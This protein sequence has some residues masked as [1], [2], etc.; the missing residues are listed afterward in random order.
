MNKS[1]FN[2]KTPS[3]K[4]EAGGVAFSLSNKEALTQLVV[5]GTFQNTFYAGGEDQLNKML[6]IAEKVDPVFVA[7]LAVYGR[8]HGF[9]KD[10][11][12]VLTALLSKV[13]V[14]LFKKVFP[15]V[16]D[17]GN[18]LRKFISA[19]RSGVVGRKSLGSAAKKQVQKLL[20]T[21]G[22]EWLFRNSIGN[23]PSMADI[24]KMVHPKGTTKE[25]NEMFK[26]LLGRDFDMLLMPDIVVDFEKFKKDATG[27]PP[28][29][30]FRL[31]S[32][33]KMSKDQW[34]YLASHMNW[35]TLRMNLNTIARNGALV[36]AEAEIAKTLSDP[37]SIKYAKVFPYQIYNTIKNTDGLPN[38]ISV[39]L[40]SALETSLQNTPQLS[41]KT[42]VALDVSGS[43]FTPV[44]GYNGSVSTKVS[45]YD[46]AMLF[47]AAIT[48][49]NDQSRV[50][51]F[52]SSARYVDF[53]DKSLNGVM[54]KLLENTGGGTEV[55]S[56]MAAVGSEHYDNIVIISDNQSWAQ[57]QGENAF[58]RALKQY[59]KN[60]NSRVKVA[61]WDI[62]PYTSTPATS[63]EFVLN[64][65]GYSDSVFE[66]LDGFFN[67]RDTSSLIQKI[68]SLQLSATES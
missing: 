36:E 11:P 61:L 56:V 43:M 28:A 68:E 33:I 66:V 39:A 23:D 18:M 26:Y 67:E 24:I 20:N 10:A 25:I 55:A 54:K 16:I 5:T 34:V 40:N 64:V 7:K 37:E 52:N 46:A 65:G 45:C 58:H 53:K 51:Q 63:G 14:D 44:T 2:T 31:L 15:L 32:N 29:V 22:A 38:A 4:N 49:R 42:L 41:G 50:V 27:N 19:M 13:D 12:A 57:S 59:R 62:Q 35:H 60:V 9:M 3:V 1:L 30:D 6:D 47:A 21:K 17:N 8:K 48:H